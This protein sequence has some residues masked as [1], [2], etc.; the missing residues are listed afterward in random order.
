MKMT[1]FS[2]AMQPLFTVKEGYCPPGRTIRAED[3][4]EAFLRALKKLGIHLSPEWIECVSFS[5]YNAFSGVDAELKSTTPVLLYANTEPCRHMETLVTEAEAQSVFD[6]TGAWLFGSGLMAPAIRWLKDT[7]PEAY[8]RTDC[9]LYSSGYLTARLTGNRV[10]DASRASLS[11]LHDPRAS[12]LEWDADLCRF[13]SVGRE[14]L[15]VILAPWEPTGSVTAGAA[16]ETGLT[17]GIPVVTGAMDSICAA[18]G[19][20]VIRPGQLLDI[21][22]SAGGMGCVS[23]RPIAHR[24]L[25]FVRYAL[26]GYWFNSGPLMYSGRL[27]DWF[28]HRLAPGW[29]MEDFIRE[30]GGAPRFAGGVMFLPYI[31]GSRHP[32]WSAETCG[33]FMNLSPESDLADLGR[34]VLEGLGCAYRRILE[35]F[36]SLGVRPES[37]VPAGGDS[38]FDLWVQTKANFLQLPYLLS[39][40]ANSSARGCALLGASGIGCIPDIRAYLEREDTPVSVVRPEA[41]L[42]ADYQRYYERFIENCRRVYSERGLGGAQ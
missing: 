39:D 40:T 3:W 23:R 4:W 34:S 37:V 15:P 2:F 32:Y 42:S 41:G 12:A 1:A 31:G 35:D 17:G 14:K 19:C 20:G 16:A 21:G 27:F 29:T 9:F 24:R 11:V 38:K 22:G 30:V 6:R 18:L 7:S 33:H 10:I 25:Y 8:E 26:P 13:F 5:G 28:I 36:S